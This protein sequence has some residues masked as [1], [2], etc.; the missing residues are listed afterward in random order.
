MQ[1]RRQSVIDEVEEQVRRVS[2]VEQ[3]VNTMRASMER[4]EA[5]MMH[6]A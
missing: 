6:M 4:V 5:M 1:N 3:N 2:N